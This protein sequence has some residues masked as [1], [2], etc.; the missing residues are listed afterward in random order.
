MEMD[1]CYLCL[2]DTLSSELIEVAQ[3][4]F[5]SG[6]GIGSV[7]MISAGMILVVIGI[8]SRAAGH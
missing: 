4:G 8:I 3:R 7:C 2:P 5:A 6:F 1:S